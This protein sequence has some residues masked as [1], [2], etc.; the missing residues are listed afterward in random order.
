MIITRTPF[1][2]SFAGGGS[3]LPSFYEKHEGCVLSASLNKYMYIIVHPSFSKDET[4]VKYR[5]MEI[6]KDIADIQHPIARQVLMDHNL[7]GVEVASVSDIPA[8]TGLAS[9]SAYTVGTLNAVGAYVGKIHSQE[10]LA[11]DACEVEITKLGEPIGKQD[12]YGVAVGGLKFIRFMT[13]GNVA[14]TP[15]V[16]AKDTL[17][18]LN[19]NLM[20]FYTGNV[21]SASSILSEQNKNVSDQAKFNNLVKM[22]ELTYELKDA[23]QNN[24]LTSFGSILHKGWM[25][26][27]ELAN[28]ITN[29]LIDKYYDIA[30]ENGA[31][32]GKL[33]GAGGGGFLLM[34]VPKERQDKLRNALSDLSLMDFSFDHDGSKIIFVGDKT[35]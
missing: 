12:Q 6:V 26:K 3:D 25:L 15:I 35:W 34:Y 31:L 16:L 14:V 22:T 21:R 28:G 5:K 17:E 9:S 8:G 13:N 11:H 32:G 18:E 4:I 19:G 20:M 2:I 27:R 1:R 10:R 24:D 23:L 33:L 29:P 7:S 30:M